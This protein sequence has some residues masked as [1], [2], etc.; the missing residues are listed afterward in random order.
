MSYIIGTVTE[1]EFIT[2]VKG[3]WEVEKPPVGFAGIA[4]EGEMV[5]MVP[6]DAKLVDLLS[7]EY[8]NRGKDSREPPPEQIE[9][10]KKP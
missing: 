1:N 6:I 5:I 4:K 10:G 8:M 2:M 7:Y 9:E 3:G